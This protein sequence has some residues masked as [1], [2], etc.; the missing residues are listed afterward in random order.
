VDG[1]QVEVFANE[2]HALVGVWHCNEMSASRS[3]ATVFGWRNNSVVFA[4]E[5]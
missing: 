4:V 2:A 3:G 1:A 5:T